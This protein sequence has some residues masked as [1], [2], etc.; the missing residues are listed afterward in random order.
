MGRKG[1]LLTLGLVF[2]TGLLGF[3]VA[4]RFAGCQEKAQP[5]ASEIP[6]GVLQDDLLDKMVGEWRLSGK[7]EGQPMNHSVRARWVLNH[8]FIEIHEKDLDQPKGNEV[9][10][11]AIVYVGYEATRQRYVAHWLDV[12][13]DGSPTL[14]YGK[15][16]GSALQFDFGYPGQPWLT[17]FRWN[18]ATNTWQ[19]LMQTK[20]KQGQ[21]QET[22]NMTLVRA[23]Q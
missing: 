21:W 16:T 17:T 4:P 13:G 22:A 12:F 6:K 9:G 15:R 19:W 11:E 2:A 18:G 8:Q 3:C 1:L 20:T 14:G 5:A 10:Y 7:F 23:S